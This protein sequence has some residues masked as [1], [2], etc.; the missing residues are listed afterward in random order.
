[1]I[2]TYIYLQHGV[3][4]G[5]VNEMIRRLDSNFPNRVWVANVDDWRLKGKC[6]EVFMVWGVFI[7]VL[8]GGGGRV[9][10]LKVLST[11]GA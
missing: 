1:M 11:H 8:R 2:D 5:P 6:K 7:V 3:I 9:A 4:R 10:K